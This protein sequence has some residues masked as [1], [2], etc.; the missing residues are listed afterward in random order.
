MLARRAALRRDSVVTGAIA[1]ERKSTVGGTVEEAGLEVEVA[2]G[3]AF[4]SYGRR[5]G[6]QL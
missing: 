1:R 6:R 2:A 4:L 3:R 5:C